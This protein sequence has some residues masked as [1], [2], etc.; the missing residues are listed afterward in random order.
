[1]LFGD[2]IDLLI[3]TL[4]QESLVAT[5]GSLGGYFNPK[6]AVANHKEHKERKE[7]NLG[8]GWS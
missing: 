8:K 2:I 1:L 6:R 5:D 7:G 3:A 4:I